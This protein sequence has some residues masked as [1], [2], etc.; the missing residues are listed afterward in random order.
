MAEHI[1]Y[2]RPDEKAKNGKIRYASKERT[3]EKIFARFIIESL[4]PIGGAS[5]WIES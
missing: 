4:H 5:F 3:D 2:Y 1:Y